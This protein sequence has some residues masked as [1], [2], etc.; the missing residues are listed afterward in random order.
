[1]TYIRI[2]DRLGHQFFFMRIIQPDLV[3]S[4]LQLRDR[5]CLREIIR[6]LDVE[7][8]FIPARKSC[9]SVMIELMAMFF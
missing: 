1:M 3:I 7:K 2:T 8:D 4:C 9:F 6:L 5:L